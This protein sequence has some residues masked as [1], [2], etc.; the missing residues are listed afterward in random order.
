MRMTM[1]GATAQKT[2]KVGSKHAQNMSV[3][4]YCDFLVV[5]LPL[6]CSSFFL[7]FVPFFLS[8]FV[9]PLGITFIYLFFSSYFLLFIFLIFLCLSS[10]FFF[11]LF[12]FFFFPLSFFAFLS[13]FFLSF[14]FLSLCCLCLI[15]LPLAFFLFHF[16]FGYYCYKKKILLMWSPFSL[17]FSI[18]FLSFF[19]F[20]SVFFLSCFP[21]F[22]LL[23]TEVFCSTK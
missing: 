15:P 13:L 14:F 2:K 3:R 6:S 22:Q 5:L 16:S 17:S 9:S 19:F 23:V 21:P 1:T 20:L 4:Q 10:S 11:L 18:P 12:F 8:F 7:S